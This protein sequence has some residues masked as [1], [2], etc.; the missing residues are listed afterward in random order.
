MVMPRANSR[1]LSIAILAKA[2]LP[3]LVKTRLVSELGAGGAATLQAELIRHTVETAC[4]ADIGPVTLW[5]S[6]DVMHPIFAAL[7]ARFSIALVRQPDGDLGARMLAAVEAA[8]GALVIGT[9]C[10]ALRPSHLRAAADAIRRGAEVVLIPAEDG[11]YVLIGL[12]KPEPALFTDMSWS[13][14]AVMAETRAR[15]AR[16]GLLVHELPALWDVDRPQD[17]HRLR[18]TG[19]AHL[20]ARA[21]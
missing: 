6:P 13:T 14:S 4:A 15:I 7:A 17:L 5:A 3:G 18:A 11:G 9:D 1:L 10:P 19:L 16:L 8:D 21:Q 12:G 20:L 2:P